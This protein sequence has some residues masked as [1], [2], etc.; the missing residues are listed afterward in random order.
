[1]V[2]S[3]MVWFELKVEDTKMLDVDV[4]NYIRGEEI[5]FESWLKDIVERG[6]RQTRESEERQE[7]ALK[8][9]KIRV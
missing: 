3:A 8:K 4:S 1:M 9:S 5:D 7:E 6:K 2:K